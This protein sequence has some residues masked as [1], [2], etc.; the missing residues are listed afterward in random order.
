MRYRFI[1]RSEVVF[2]IR[3]MCRALKV[4]RSSYYHWKCQAERRELKAELDGALVVEI[5]RVHKESDKRY[6][7][8]RIAKELR[9]EGRRVN[10]KR[11]ARLMRLSGIRA[12]TTKRFR[13]LSDARTAHPPAV[14]DLV[15]RNFQTETL[16]RVWT[17]DITYLWTHEGWL[18]L[19]IVLDLFHRKIIGYG[20]SSRLTAELVQGALQAA[21]LGRESMVSTGELIFH[22]DRGSQY[23][24]SELQRV[25][26]MHGIRQSMGRSCFDNAITESVFHTIKTELFSGD[27]GRTWY[28]KTRKEAR[29]MIF[30][31]IEVFY[32]RKRLHSS[33]DYRTPEEVEQQVLIHCPK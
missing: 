13:P 19:A 17:S 25:L 15:Q 31:Y 27:D 3:G 32:N 5:R 29:E 16:N 7:S 10:R 8:P 21:L 20:T 30:E 23:R 28:P 2:R 12:K 6:G 1:E 9:R 33:L 11:I 18:Y 24:S 14:P 22:S 26:T 4:S